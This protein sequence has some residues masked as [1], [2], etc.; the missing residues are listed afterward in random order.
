MAKENETAPKGIQFVIQRIFIKDISME[1]PLTP[2]LFK[3]TNWQPQIDVRLN[4]SN[5]KVADN[6]FDVTLDMEITAKKGD[7]TAFLVELKHGGIFTIANC[8][9]EEL[10][11][12]LGS[13]CASVIYPYSR[14]VVSELVNKAGF[15]PLYLA[16]VNFDALFDAK[17]KQAAGK[18]A[19]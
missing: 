5:K 11:R 6:V 14:E 10:E 9:E 15:P 17:K 4:T 3:E 13:Y 7:Q 1:S 19:S 12:L 8:K 18:K 2:E 16:P